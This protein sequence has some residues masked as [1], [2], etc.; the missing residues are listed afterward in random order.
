MTNIFQL[1]DS[2]LTK[3]VEQQRQKV[4]RVGRTFVPS[5]T[6]EDILN[7]Q[8]FPELNR[9]ALFNYEDGILAGLLSAQI[10]LRAEYRK[11]SATQENFNRSGSESPGD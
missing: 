5:L 9:S 10:A 2:L 7:P 3:L 6:F 11:Q 8:T 4:L 1:A